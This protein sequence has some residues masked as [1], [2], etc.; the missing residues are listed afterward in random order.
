MTHEILEF[1]SAGT[2]GAHEGRRG[3][4]CA[5]APG[6]LETQLPPW[7]T[8]TAWAAVAAIA[9]AALSGCAKD[10]R[11]AEREKAYGT[12]SWGMSAFHRVV[13]GDK[14]LGFQF[15]GFLV[16]VEKAYRSRIGMPNPEL[17]VEKCLDLKKLEGTG[18]QDED[19]VRALRKNVK[20]FMYDPKGTFISHL[21]EYSIHGAGTNNLQRIRE[22]IFL[23]AYADEFDPQEA[24]ERGFNAVSAGCESAKD[25]LRVRIMDNLKTAK[26]EGHAYTHI[27]LYA[28]GW[29]TDEQETIRNVNSLV[30]HLHEQR[31]LLRPP[32]D[33][34]F[35]PLVVAIAWPSE[36][37]WPYFEPVGKAF[38]YPVKS[39]DA[40]EIGL[41][42]ANLILRHILVPAKREYGIPLILIGH[43][44]GAR[45]L[46]R[47]V[48]SAHA[49]ESPSGVP[50][51]SD[52]VDLVVG[53]QG[54]FSVNRFIP[55]RGREGTPYR[56]FQ[57]FARKYVFTWSEHDHATPWAA[58]VTGALHVGGRPGYKRSCKYPK[59]FAQFSV[60]TGAPPSIELCPQPESQYDDGK[61]RSWNDALADPTRI[62]MVDA[63]NI[64]RYE[65]HEHF[66]KAHSDIFTPQIA[67]LIW[68]SI[69]ALRKSPRPDRCDDA[70]AVNSGVEDCAFSECRTLLRE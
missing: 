48:M 23:D 47:A 41:L 21:V 9:A 38:S 50:V 26:T 44:F 35:K 22:D 24:F 20:D 16:G 40:D 29:N 58:F 8:Q 12:H 42:W 27:L 56:D 17:L 67:Q 14:G 68:F 61:S 53:L 46:T 25:C 37:N 52:D 32:P 13:E 2:T 1:G 34:H 28:M 18:D 39:G 69:E 6:R 59:L 62:V 31:L 63:S 66:G 33:Q 19:D 4:K 30:T 64:V 65:S 57:K 36:W 70:N 11:I 15:P 60:K 7:R 54:A 5:V 55:S 10:T 49:L 3:G 45:L 51:C 43:S